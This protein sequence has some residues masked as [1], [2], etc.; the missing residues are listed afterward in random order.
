MSPPFFS[1]QPLPQYNALED[2]H[3]AQFFARKFGWTLGEIPNSKT[4][5]VR[6]E[7]TKHAEPESLSPAIF[8]C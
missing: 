3:L 8:I 2:P 1:L 4:A 7:A 5:S 6:R